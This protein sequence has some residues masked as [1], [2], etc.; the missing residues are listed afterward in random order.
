MP[1]HRLQ[2]RSPRDLPGIPE[3][4]ARTPQQLTPPTGS[5]ESHPPPSVHPQV[6]TL[7]IGRMASSLTNGRL[8]S[9]PQLQCSVMAPSSSQGGVKGRDARV[10]VGTTSGFGRPS[11]PSESGVHTEVKKTLFFSLIFRLKSGPMAC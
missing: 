10:F 8:R 1:S 7:S 5:E 3:T 9:T 2:R 6:T 11:S 4:K